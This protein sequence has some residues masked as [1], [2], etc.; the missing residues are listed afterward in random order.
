MVTYDFICLDCRG[1]F[2][3]DSA[4]PIEG[5]GVACPHCGSGRTR[6]TFESYRRAALLAWSPD[7]L[8]QLRSCHFG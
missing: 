7:R 5:P 2:R 6:Q 1:S 8:D 4:V 3:L